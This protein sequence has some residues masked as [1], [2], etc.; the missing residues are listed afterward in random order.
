MSAA[1]IFDLLREGRSLT[2]QS[3]RRLEGLIRDEAVRRV[4]ERHG[5]TMEFAPSPSQHKA[6][7]DLEEEAIRDAIAAA[8]PNTRTAGT[9]EEGARS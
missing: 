3:I 5:F 8:P 7:Y 4:D 6:E 1:D 2:E 9:E